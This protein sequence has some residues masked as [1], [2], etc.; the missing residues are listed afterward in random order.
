MKQKLTGKEAV[1]AYMEALEHPFKAE[2]EAVR[3]IILAANPKM[4]ERIK[5]N[6]PSFYFDKDFAAFNP[7]TRDFA[8]LVMVFHDGAM[9]Q[10][11]MGLLE[12]DYK[13]RRLASFHSMEDVLAKKEALEKVVNLWIGFVEAGG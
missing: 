1:D 12:G 4:E 10:D 7:R 8:Q 3:Q 9:V 6:A 13:D 11:R 2:I 5:W